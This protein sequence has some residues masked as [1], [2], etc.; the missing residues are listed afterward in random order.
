M[1]TLTKQ[2][3]VK[4]L[5]AL[6]LAFMLRL[7]FAP[8]VF[9]HC[10]L[11]VA[12][13]GFGITLSRL[14]GVDDVIT[15]VWMG[16]F[17]GSVAFWTQSLLGRKRRVFFNPFWRLIIYV[18]VFLSTVWSF[19]KFNLVIKHD[20]IFG[21]DKLTFGIV[22]GGIVF[23]LVDLFSD[24]LIKIRGRSLFPYQRLVF[25]LVST[26]VQSAFFYILINY[27]I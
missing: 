11:C 13:A 7:K 3:K 17:L 27:Y 4:T 1:T 22:V 5:I 14:L 25:G 21:Y 2:F 20:G 16:A 19:Y 10:P 8:L 26:F 6:V 9:A 18:L 24:F 15:G 12:G 23:Y